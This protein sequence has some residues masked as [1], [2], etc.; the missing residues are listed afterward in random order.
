MCSSATVRTVCI[1]T[2]ETAHLRGRFGGGVDADAGKRAA[3]LDYDG[4]GLLDL[5]VCHYDLTL[6]TNR[7]CGDQ[8]RE[9]DLLQSD[10]G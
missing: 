4:D 3:F 9:S 5:Y 2:R 10:F 7:Y 6:E 8:A 1:G